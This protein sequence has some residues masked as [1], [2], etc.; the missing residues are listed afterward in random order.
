[1]NL[2]RKLSLYQEPIS[3]EDPYFTT[4]TPIELIQK[5]NR[6]IELP[7][8]TSYFPK[9]PTPSNPSFRVFLYSSNNSFISKELHTI[10][11]CLRP[12][13]LCL[14]LTSEEYQFKSHT[15]IKRESILR[16]LFEQMKK[17]QPS[18]NQTSFYEYSHKKLKFIDPKTLVIRN[19]RHFGSCIHLID[20]EPSITNKRL[21]R[22]LEMP[23]VGEVLNTDY[24]IPY[25][26]F[27]LPFNVNLFSKAYLGAFTTSLSRFS[28]ILSSGHKLASKLNQTI[29]NKPIRELFMQIYQHERE[30][31][32]ACSLAHQL[33]YPHYHSNPRPISPPPP[34]PPLPPKT[35]PFPSKF[36][37]LRMI[38]KP[39]PPSNIPPLVF[40]PFFSDSTTLIPEAYPKAQEPDEIP[41]STPQSE[42]RILAVVSDSFTRG[43]VKKWPT[44]LNLSREK[45]ELQRQTLA[46]H[47]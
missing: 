43:M 2:K 15:I 17:V 38:P 26:S 25:D 8:P 13:I 23:E 41:H 35:P 47:L 14:D 33:D 30:I 4:V 27:S 3:A 18:L 20:R 39:I 31:Y 9:H 6:L 24:V 44:I 36:Q 37:I 21:E 40:S 5:Y 22:V 46:I 7:I 11:L 12:S 32:L 16:D 42:H 10:F 19:A 1:M 34:E 29:S 28:H 45:R